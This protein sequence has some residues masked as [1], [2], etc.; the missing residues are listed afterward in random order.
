MTTKRI[1][2]A[3]TF[4]AQMAHFIQ[5]LRKHATQG[6]DDSQY[7]FALLA[8]G[9]IKA[10]DDVACFEAN[11]ADN[12][13]FD[14]A[15]AQYDAVVWFALTPRDDA[16]A[17]PGSV[18][19]IELWRAFQL[20]RALQF[21]A[22][23]LHASIP[24]IFATRIFPTDARPLGAVYDHWRKL[25]NIFNTSVDNLHIIRSSI[26]ISEDDALF[27]AFV[28]YATRHSAPDMSRNMSWLNVARP[29]D[30]GSM[31]KAI[32]DAL[33]SSRCDIAKRRQ[34]NLVGDGVVS[35]A[36]LLAA[37]RRG[38][39]DKHMI[40]TRMRCLASPTARRRAQF[41]AETR[42]FHAIDDAVPIPYDD[43]H[44]ECSSWAT[45]R[46]E[47][48]VDERAIP[49]RL[50]LDVEPLRHHDASAFIVRRIANAPKRSLYD[51][52]QLLMHW[53]PSY[54]K[55]SL[56]IEK[57]SGDLLLCKISRITLCE[58]EQKADAPFFNRLIVHRPY[59][60][61]PL[62]TIGLAMLPVNASD[63]GTLLVACHTPSD[64]RLLCSLFARVI[65][66]FGLFV[67]EYG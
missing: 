17:V 26:E 28:E 54:F 44:A 61:S 65:H 37:V 2:L 19:D 1:L 62:F 9:A 18:Y 16:T 3:G 13:S 50:L 53:L 57:A 67:E 55:K 66:A 14:K 27:M 10:L 21:Q 4:D 15:I 56:N 11:P 47:D 6:D 41:F 64:N 12:V 31:S 43:R 20:A 34:T 59:T 46:A 52:T 36:E 32:A 39:H 24:L 48:I 45:Q 38:L 60:H 5:H 63:A 33:Q 29:V 42:K 22:S 58:I 23:A 8:S 7:K 35:Y 49:V 25:Y 51:T 30:K 40:A